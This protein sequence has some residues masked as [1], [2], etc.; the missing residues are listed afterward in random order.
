MIN[1]AIRYRPVLDELARRQ[2]ARVLEVG[3]G[4]EGLAMFWSGPVTGV[5][6][7]FKRRP[8]HRPVRGSALALPF[9]GRSWPLVV[10]CDTLE[11]ILPVDR[12]AALSELAR[13][14]GETLL[15][16]FPSGPA[17]TTCYQALARRLGEPRPAWLAEHLAHPLPQ[18]EPAVARL[19]EAGF[20][21]SV[22]WF[23]SA[24]A[25]ARLM[26]WESRR[27]VQALT[28]GLM[29]LAGRWLAPRWPVAVGDDDSL[30]RAFLIAE[31]KR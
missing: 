17:A 15:L 5:D 21:V 14:S 30:L 1:F 27:P 20:T 13:V 31:R 10:S 3:S 28:Y 26:A 2:P 18:V 19:E 12:P 25:H 23:E 29:R 7:A 16:A 6:L 9:A 11:H 24:A 22:S 8:L 4:P